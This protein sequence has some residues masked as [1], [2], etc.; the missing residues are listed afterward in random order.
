MMDS[1]ALAKTE[2][3]NLLQSKAGTQAVDLVVPKHIGIIMDGNRRWAENRGL[4][5]SRGHE[6]GA[7]ALERITDYCAR[8]GVEALTVYAFSTENWHSRTKM[9][10]RE[11]FGLIKLVLKRRLK[12]MQD[13]GVVLGLI[14][15]V[16]RFPL[17]LRR[18]LFHAKEVL[19]KN[20]RIKLNLALNYGGRD[21]ILRAFKKITEQRVSAKEINE[22]L[23]SQHLDTNGLPEPDLIIR[24]GGRQRLS[25]FLVW[26]CTYSELYFTDALWPDFGPEELD[27]AILYYSQ[28]ERNFGK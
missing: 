15:D 26:Q 17:N 12:K 1:F 21:E 10:I 4:A 9:E 24:T 19:K 28:C 3:F 11:L 23:L 13:N 14:G 16:Q 22:E 25:N 6:A 2:A 5:R 8:V 7:I 18:V 27:K 20:N